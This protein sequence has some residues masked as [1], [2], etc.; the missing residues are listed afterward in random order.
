M[1]PPGGLRLTDPAPALLTA[2]GLASARSLRGC[3]EAEIGQLEA[4]YG[5]SLPAAYRRFL[6]R[7]GRSAGE[8]LGGTDWLFPDLLELREGAESLLEECE[9][10]QSLDR[11]D[12]VFAMHQGYQFL[13]FKCG[14]GPDPEVFYYLEDVASAFGVLDDAVARLDDAPWAAELRGLTAVFELFLG[15]PHRALEIA[16][17]HL[18]GSDG[19]N[20]VEAITAAAPALVVV[21][22]A[23]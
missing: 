3:T 11:N 6:Q 23:E 4:H 20:L 14:T 15:R 18:E 10:T 1:R 21:G 8:C 22:R 12:F 17:P 9:A 7:M 13:F 5:I 16:Q 2:A 19:R